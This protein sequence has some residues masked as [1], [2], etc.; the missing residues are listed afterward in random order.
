M[1]MQREIIYKQRREVLDGENLKE[2]IQKM[3]DSVAEELTNTYVSEET[4]NKEAFMQDIKSTFGIEKLHS[5][6]R[7]KSKIV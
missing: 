6:K 7:R 5:I 2:Q 4:V 3:M 1:N